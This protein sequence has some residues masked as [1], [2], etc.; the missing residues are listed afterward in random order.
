M[1]SIF[2]QNTVCIVNIRTK[3]SFVLP[4]VEAEED[5]FYEINSVSSGVVVCYCKNEIDEKIC[6]I[7]GI[8]NAI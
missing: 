2:V 7:L 3:N 8:K 5:K 1:A 6:C 4:M